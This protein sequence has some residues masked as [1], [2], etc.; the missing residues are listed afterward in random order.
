[1]AHRLATRGTRAV[2]AKDTSGSDAKAAA[3]AD[4][5]AKKAAT[6]AAEAAE[7]GPVSSG[8][9]PNMKTCKECKK[10][11]NANSKKGCQ[12]CL[13]QLFGGSAPSKGKKKK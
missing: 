5:A 9:A 3:A 1:M 6:K 12:N 2:G 7:G 10:K 11:Y 4:N 8:G 13:D